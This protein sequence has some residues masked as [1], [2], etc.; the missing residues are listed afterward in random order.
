M[1]KVVKVCFF[2]NNNGYI[3]TNKSKK[4]GF[5]ANYT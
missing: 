3:Y 2:F 4:V 5:V 1:G